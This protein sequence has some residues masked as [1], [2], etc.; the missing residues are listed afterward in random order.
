MVDNTKEKKTFE[1]APRNKTESDENHRTATRG[2]VQP[3][4]DQIRRY[5]NFE[6]GCHEDK[7]VKISHTYDALFD[8]VSSL[9]SA[10][11]W[12]GIS[13]EEKEIV[14]KAMEILYFEKPNMSDMEMEVISKYINSD[15]LMLE[16]GTGFSTLHFA[17][18]CKHIV[19]VEHVL[20]WHVRIALMTQILQM[21]NISALFAAPTLDDIIDDYQNDKERYAPYINILNGD[22]KTLDIPEKTVLKDMKFDVV[23][24]DGAARS[25]CAIAILPNLREDSVVMIS[26]FWR[27]QRQSERNYSDV[28][29]YYDEVESCKEGNSYVILKKKK[30]L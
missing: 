21:R 28:F 26:D 2:M 13:S 16:F 11:Y 6:L 25:E 8:L 17:R 12:P 1:S 10:P 19:S 22:I 24:I 3:I 4:A 5:A 9:Y 20:S 14:R 23:S 7:R 27:E 18:K 29:Q 15:T 30:G